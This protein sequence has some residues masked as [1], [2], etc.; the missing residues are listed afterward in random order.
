LRRSLPER[1]AQ[2][3]ASYKCATPL[4][5]QIST[6]ESSSSIEARL[7][8][9]AT[10]RDDVALWLRSAPAL[11]RL[12]G[13]NVTSVPGAFTPQ[14]A[15][16]LFSVPVSATTAIQARH[17]LA[18]LTVVDVQPQ[19]AGG[20]A[21][22]MNTPLYHLD[23]S[24]QTIRELRLF[25]PCADPR[26]LQVGSRWLGAVM[27]TEPYST[28]PTAIDA[29]IGQERLMLVPGF[30]LPA[31]REDLIRTADALAKVAIP[32]PPNP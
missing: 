23:I 31:E 1:D 9:T 2:R 21:I 5:T 32:R 18:L 29:Q 3:G 17:T 27:G 22:R 16:A 13:T 4:T 7:P 15:P 20:Y 30:L 26:L 24:G 25:V 14:A 19:A 6:T 8:A 12:Y 11:L 28:S 10:N